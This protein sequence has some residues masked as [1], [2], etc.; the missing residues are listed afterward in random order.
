[1][2]NELESQLFLAVVV[3]FYSEDYSRGD[4]GYG[5]GD[6]KRPI[7]QE[8]TL[9]NE[10]HATCAEQQEGWHGYAIGVTGAYCV[11]C[12]WDIAAY[13]AYGGSGAYYVDDKF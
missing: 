3:N 11:P 10:K 13:H 4:G 6:H 1:M 8:Q 5:V 7:G 12:L 2:P 9:D